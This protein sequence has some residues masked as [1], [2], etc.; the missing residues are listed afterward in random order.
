[1]VQLANPDS[2][3]WAEVRGL[4]LNSTMLIEQENEQVSCNGSTTQLPKYSEDI[5]NLQIA[6]TFQASKCRDT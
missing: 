3:D 1:M 5:I 2:K 4:D 6:I